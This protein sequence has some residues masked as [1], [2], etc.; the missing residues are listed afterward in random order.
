MSKDKQNNHQEDSNSSNH[1][2]DEISFP[3]IPCHF[4]KHKKH[5]PQ[6]VISHFAS[7]PEKED[8]TLFCNTCLRDLQ[9]KNDNEFQSYDIEEFVE[10]FLRKLTAGYMECP[11]PTPLLQQSYDLRTQ[12][13]STFKKRVEKEIQAVMQTFESIIQEVTKIILEKRDATLKCYN[14][15]SDIFTQSYDLFSVKYERLFE[16]GDKLAKLK[17]TSENKIKDDLQNTE[18]QED[19]QV[20]L[21]E[22]KALDDLCQEFGNREKKTEELSR[23]SETLQTLYHVLPPVTTNKKSASDL[24]IEKIKEPLEQVLSQCAFK[25]NPIIQKVIQRMFV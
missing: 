13:A 25:K 1:F 6:T 7:I 12:H 8:Y 4:S 11:V 15:I 24:G 23:F 3:F 22:L 16:S 2:I 17:E 20:F 18:S 14:S 21:K 10:N 5:G 19:Y 9:K